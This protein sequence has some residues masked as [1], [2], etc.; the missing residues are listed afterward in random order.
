M[1]DES[2]L[3]VEIHVPLPKLREG[4]LGPDDD[5]YPWVDDVLN[6]LEDLDDR[7]EASIIDDGEE[8]DGAFVFSLA[9]APEHML[10]AVATRVAG[11]AGV[12]TGV[13][14]V[15]TDDLAEEFGMGRRVELS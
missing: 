4:E 6:Y 8:F 1:I 5:P 10:L 7:G 11:I 3:I 9:D 2:D 13:F 14:A 12:P 15:V